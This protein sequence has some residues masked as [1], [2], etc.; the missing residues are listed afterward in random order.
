MVIRNHM[1][2]LDYFEAASYLFEDLDPSKSWVTPATPF[3][4]TTS[5]CSCISSVNGGSKRISQS[6][7]LVYLTLPPFSL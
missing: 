3:R 2:T 5:H 4:R 1:R 7:N 6:T